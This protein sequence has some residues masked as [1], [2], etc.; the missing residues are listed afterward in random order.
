MFFDGFA[1][2]NKFNPLNPENWSHVTVRQIVA[3]V[4]CKSSFN[5]MKFIHRVIPVVYIGFHENITTFI[6]LT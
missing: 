1:K 3:K 5:V 2:E 6:Y 4:M